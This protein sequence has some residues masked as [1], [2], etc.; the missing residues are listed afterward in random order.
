MPLRWMPV[1]TMRARAVLFSPAYTTAPA[2]RS[3]TACSGTTDA[4]RWMSSVTSPRTL[5]AGRHPPGFLTS[6]MTSTVW[7][8]VLKAGRISRTTPTAFLPSSKL[9]R[10]TGWPIFSRRTMS[11][12]NGRHIKAA[13]QIAG[14]IVGLR[15]AH[16]GLGTD[17]A[18]RQRQVA[19]HHLRGGDIDDF[20]RR[21]LF[22]FFSASGHHDNQCQQKGPKS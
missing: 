8:M 13:R 14:G 19:C 20:F 4:L 10:F 16:P 18:F 3:T 9:V 21:F 6:T 2:G 22:R 5:P 1:F 11:S 12:G 15:L 17:R 7:V